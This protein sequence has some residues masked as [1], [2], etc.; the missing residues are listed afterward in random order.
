MALK[1]VVATRNSGKIREI[2]KILSGSGIEMKR[3]DDFPLFPEPEETGDSFFDNAL[4]KARAAH[5]ATGLAALADDSGIEVDALGGR[6]G[7][8][9]ARY[10]GEG[11]SDP[12]RWKLLLGELKGKTGE[13]RRARFRCVMVLY[14]APGTADRIFMS[15]GILEGM[16]AEEPAGSN[17]FGYDPVFYVPGEGM[18]VA[19]MDPGRKNMISHRYRALVEMKGLIESGGLEKE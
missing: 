7:V 6:P 14:P 15:E 10:G 3:L 2:E 17:G 12:D 8:E 5:K 19:Q 13:E 4:I 16:I 18:T 11:A 9:S 1:I